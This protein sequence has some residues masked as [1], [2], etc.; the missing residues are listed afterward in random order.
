MLYDINMFVEWLYQALVHMTAFIAPF[1]LAFL[2]WIRGW[3]W[4]ALLPFGLMVVSTLTLAYIGVP[5]TAQ[6]QS[7]MGAGSLF[8]WLAM[9]VYYPKERR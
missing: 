2:A 6:L 8:M 1:L 5:M 9:I 3:K 4:L 7:S